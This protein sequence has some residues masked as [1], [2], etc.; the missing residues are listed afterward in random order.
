MANV[1]RVWA[2]L[3]AV[4]VDVSAGSAQYW[5]TTGTAAEFDR[6]VDYAAI[7][8]QREGAPG[9]NEYEVHDVS[10]GVEGVGNRLVAGH[11]QGFQPIWVPRS[12]PGLHGSHWGVGR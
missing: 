5:Q 10:H 9:T 1:V 8:L 12:I 7:P 6:C 11:E 2:E 3:T 4:R